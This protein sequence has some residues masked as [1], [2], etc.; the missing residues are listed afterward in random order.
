MPRAITHLAAIGLAIA[1]YT[2]WVLCDRVIKLAGRS[3]L[4]GREIVGFL[5]V[6]MAGFMALYAMERGEVRGLWPKRPRR[7][8]VRGLLGVGSNLCVIVA[9]RHLSLTLSQRQRGRELCG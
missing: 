9:L 2:C 4:P 1:G 7:Q 3:V 8:F 5:G 6:F